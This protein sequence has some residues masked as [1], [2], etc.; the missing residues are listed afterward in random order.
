MKAFRFPLDR[1]LQWRTSQCELE[2]AALGRLL[3]QRSQLLEALEQISGLRKRAADALVS[4]REIESATFHTI[5]NFNARTDQ[6]K[7]M[8]RT[9]AQVLEREIEQQQRKTAEA[10]RK[11]KLLET[12]RASRHNQWTVQL[13]AENEQVAADSWLARF[14]AERYTTT[15]AFPPSR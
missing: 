3:S 9:R 12:L 15:N 11:K 6:Q 5:G 8:I 10:R 4:E 14:S 7:A 13:D 1:V 2:E